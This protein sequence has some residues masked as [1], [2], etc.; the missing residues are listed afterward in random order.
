MS[1]AIRMH[2]WGRLRS[3]IIAKAQGN[4]GF[5]LALNR[6]KFLMAESPVLPWDFLVPF[7]GMW[8]SRPL[9]AMYPYSEL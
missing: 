5:T 6:R 3:S 1:K 4:A 2:C 9:T 7:P 8:W